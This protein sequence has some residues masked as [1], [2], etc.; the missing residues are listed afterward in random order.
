MRNERGKTFAIAWKAIIL[1]FSCK[2]SCCTILDQ[3]FRKS[4]CETR[5]KKSSK[6]IFH[7]LVNERFMNRRMIERVFHRLETLKSF[8]F[9][10]WNLRVEVQLVKLISSLNISQSSSLNFISVKLAQANIFL[11]QSSNCSMHIQQ[12]INCALRNEKTELYERWALVHPLQYAWEGKRLPAI[13][14]LGAPLTWSFPLH[15]RNV[16]HLSWSCK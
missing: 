1:K 15:L 14:R 8:R 16:Q 10:K 5:K 4:H 9:M 3:N 2:S 13:P 12:V 7:F 6:K 11:L